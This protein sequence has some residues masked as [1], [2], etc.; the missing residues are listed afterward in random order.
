MDINAGVLRQRRKDWF[1]IN[2]ILRRW[3]SAAVTMQMAEYSKMDRIVDLYSVRRVY[4]FGFMV[5]AA[6]DLRRL[7]RL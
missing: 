4:G 1:W 7:S 6:I 3:H 2:W 5:R